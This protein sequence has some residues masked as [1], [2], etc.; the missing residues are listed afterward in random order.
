MGHRA[1]VLSDHEVQPVESTNEVADAA[2][3]SDCCDR[4]SSDLVGVAKGLEK[5]LDLSWVPCDLLSVVGSDEQH[6]V[7][8]QNLSVFLGQSV[9]LFW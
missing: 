4:I 5:V 9:P 8:K 2:R 7:V 1:V 3:C 6:Q